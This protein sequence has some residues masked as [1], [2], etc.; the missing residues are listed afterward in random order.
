MLYNATD[1]W[2]KAIDDGVLSIRTDTNTIHRVVKGVDGVYPCECHVNIEP[3][4]FLNDCSLCDGERDS[5]SGQIAC[6]LD[7]LR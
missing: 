2:R 5:T 3:C 4:H 7:S 1:A 6:H